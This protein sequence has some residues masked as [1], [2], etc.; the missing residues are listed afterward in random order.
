MIL[1]RQQLSLQRLSLEQMTQIIKTETRI[2]QINA[3]K[4]LRGDRHHEK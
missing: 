2:E 1:S 4:T 3:N